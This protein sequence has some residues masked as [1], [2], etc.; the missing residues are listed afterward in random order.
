MALSAIDRKQNI[1][2]KISHLCTNPKTKRSMYQ[3]GL[4]HQYT[5]PFSR[6]GGGEAGGGGVVGRDK[7][8]FTTARQCA[9]PFEVCAQDLR[10][11]ERCD[12][13]KI[14]ECTLRKNSVLQYSFTLYI[15]IKYSVIQQSVLQ[16]SDSIQCDTI[17]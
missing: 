5:K 8:D 11:S 14:L 3:Y 4:C 15:A 10:K 1:L 16:Y 6:E 2:R 12:L 17:Q 9:E 13:H 7:T